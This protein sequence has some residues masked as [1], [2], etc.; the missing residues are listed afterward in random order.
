MHYKSEVTAEDLQ[1]WKTLKM[2]GEKFEKD[3]QEKTEQ[4]ELRMKKL[5]EEEEQAK[6]AIFNEKY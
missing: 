3:L 6:Q 1:K 5:K 2:Q 4:Y